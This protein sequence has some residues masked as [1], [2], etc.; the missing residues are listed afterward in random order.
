[1]LKFTI[2]DFLDL[3]LEE[4]KT[5]IYVNNKLFLQCKYVLLS[6]S[7]D[8]FENTDDIYSIDEAVEKLN[9]YFEVSE[10]SKLKIPPET[11]FW[12]HC[13]NL[14]TWYENNYDTSLIHCNLAFPLLK[15]LTKVGDHVAV[16]VFKEEVARRFESNNLNVIRF[17]LY[18]KYLD[19]LNQEELDHI[20]SG[21]FD[22]AIRQL[23]ELMRSIFTNYREIKDLLDLLLFYDLN[24]NQ[25][26]ILQI[27]KH[28][29]SKY[30]IQFTQLVILH[31]NYKEFIDYRIPYG[32][33]LTYF[34]EILDFLYNNYPKINELLKIIDS[35][36]MS[37]ATSLDEKRSYGFIS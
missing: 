18:N 37:G 31:L 33:F 13:S 6:F 1:M 35:G 34:E 11:L 7:K 15:E 9:G 21:L 17:L 19:C 32:K 36:F 30:R 16:N 26:L 8:D 23:I 22:I 20:S 28:S 12:A 5:Y 24:Y 29:S 27:L 25:Y 10:D 3:R 14:Q 2:N 4:G